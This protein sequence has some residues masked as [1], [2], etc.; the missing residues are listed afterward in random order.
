MILN[1]YL[2]GLHPPQFLV[3]LLRI[4]LV[5]FKTPSNKSYSLNLNFN[6]SKAKQSDLSTLLLFN[7]LLAS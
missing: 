4:L 5:Y 1:P 6:S 2:Q 7:T 3:H